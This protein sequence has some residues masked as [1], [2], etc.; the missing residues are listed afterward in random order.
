MKIKKLGHC[1]LVI[2]TNGKRIMTDPGSY[3]ISDQEKEKNIDI[4]LITHEH[5]DHLHIDSLKKVLVN[6]P[7]AIVITNTAVGKLLLE[8]QINFEILEDKSFREINGVEFEAHDCRH[9]EIFEE[10]GQVQNTGF[11]IDKRLF[12]PGDAF[13]NPNKSVEILALPVAGPWARVRDAMKYVLEIKPKFAFPVHDGML[14]PDFGSCHRVP[15][16]V[17]PKFGIIF[18]NFE[19]NKEEEF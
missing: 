19:E 8:V 3:T 1:C 6:N 10:F 16:I 2:E 12:Y 9:E 11:F 18:K 5:P 14:D 4:V 15:S 17:L 13:H 7:T